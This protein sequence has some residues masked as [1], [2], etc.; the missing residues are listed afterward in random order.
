MIGDFLE[1][2]ATRR[3]TITLAF[4]EIEEKKT[5]EKNFNVSDLCAYSK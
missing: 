2:F 1:D 4:K 5:H 3:E